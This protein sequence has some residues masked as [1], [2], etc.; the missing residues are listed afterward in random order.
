MSVVLVTGG[1]GYV[2][3]HACKELARS[4]YTPVT[5]DNLST[6]NR[7]AV[8]WGPFEQ[9]DIRDDVVLTRVLQKYRPEAVLHFAASAYVGESMSNP[10]LYWRNNV[11]GSATLLSKLA[12]FGIAHVVFSST[13][14]VYGEPAS[15]PIDEGFETLPI[16]PY[17]RTKLAVEQML[18]DF[19][20]SHGLRHV[21]LRYF[22]A[23]GADPECEIGECHEPETHLIPIA[24]QVARG[25]RQQL[26]IFGTDYETADG[27]CV[28]DYVHVTDLAQAHI[29]SLTYLRNGGRSIALNLGAGTGLSIHQIVKAIRDVTGN[30][31][32]TK[33][34][35]R[36]PGDPAQLFADPSRA[37]QELGWHCK[38]SSPEQIVRTAWDWTHRLSAKN[39]DLEQQPR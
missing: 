15:C 18:G 37:A 28:R 26:E 10:G 30:T 4:G 3:S 38:L 17:G 9:G 8:K 1:A 22:N 11:G 20:S 19:E 39:C 13:C 6:G 36:R 27:T 14:A 35:S 2:G 32:P 31:I 29:R 5:L 34:S 24:L 12:D 33:L 7:W 16:N 25:Q 21:A 23:A